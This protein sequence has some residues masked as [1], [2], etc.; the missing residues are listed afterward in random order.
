MSQLDLFQGFTKVFK[1]RPPTRQKDPTGG[2]SPNVTTQQVD[3]YVAPKSAVFLLPDPVAC[4]RSASYTQMQKF[5]LSQDASMILLDWFTSGRK[6]LAEEWVFSRYYSVNEIIVDG[7][8]VAKDVTLLE[9]PSL[10][11]QL[12]LAR[13]LGERL[14]P[15]SCYAMLILCGPMVQDVVLRLNEKLQSLS[16]FKTTSPSPLLWAMSTADTERLSVIR[17]TGIETEDV[18]SWL[19]ESLRPLERVIGVDTYR[20]AFV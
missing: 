12:E 9:D 8:R 10:H 17:V 1:T 3:I 2:P 5:H 18:K 20:K 14:R 16:V 7:R 15:Y 11:N 4:F 13:P 6:S 19:R